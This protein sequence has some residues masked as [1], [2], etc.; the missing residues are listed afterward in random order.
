MRE[1][2]DF[3]FKG[4]EKQHI[5]ATQFGATKTDDK[6]EFKATFDNASLTLVINFLLDN[7]FFNF[8]NLTF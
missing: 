7:C 1:L 4:G 2:I 3:Y 8:G 5:T 6:N